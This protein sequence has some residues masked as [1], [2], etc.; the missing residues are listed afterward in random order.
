VEGLGW[1]MAFSDHELLIRTLS[2][3]PGGSSFLDRLAAGVLE[4]LI[5]F[6]LSIMDALMS[7]CS[8]SDWC[9]QLSATSFHDQVTVDHLSH[10]LS[11]LG[12]RLPRNTSRTILIDL[13]RLMK[14]SSHLDDL[15]AWSWR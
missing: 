9:L 8:V 3:L 11:Q 12:G 2:F 13:V 10:T 15:L 7:R 14:S 1:P 4:S 5:T 6:L